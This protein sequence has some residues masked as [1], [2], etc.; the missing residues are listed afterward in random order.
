MSNRQMRLNLRAGQ[1][2]P[3][4]VCW[5]IDDGYL[6]LVSWSDQAEML[7]LGIWGPG[8]VVIPSLVSMSP[9]ELLSISAVQVEEC[10]PSPQEQQEFLMDQLRQVS[11][12]LLLTR[13]R[14]AEHRLYQLLLWLGERFGRVN[15]RGVSL[16]LA[17]MNLTHRQLA[18]IAATT[19]VT[20]TKA[21]TRFRLERLMVKD[22]NDELLVRSCRYDLP[23][24]D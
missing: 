20:V 6:R 23:T 9:I 7:T 18:E 13:I 16:S 4:E 2:L 3:S 24:P 5:R 8:E 14:P 22:G 15:S 21:I 19:R 17:D 11:T 1:S 12:M 10:Q